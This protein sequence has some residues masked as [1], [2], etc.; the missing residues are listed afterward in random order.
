MSPLW[1]LIIYSMLV[2][3]TRVMGYYHVA[4]AGLLP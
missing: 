2:P 4:P 1:G 3:M